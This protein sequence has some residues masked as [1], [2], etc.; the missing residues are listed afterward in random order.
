MDAHLPEHLRDVEREDE[1][2]ASE[3][4]Q[5][6]RQ[7]V[8]DCW[9]DPQNVVDRDARGRLRRPVEHDPQL[10]CRTRGP[11]HAVV[12]QVERRSQVLV[13]RFFDH[14]HVSELL[15]LSD[16]LRVLLLQFGLLVQFPLQSQK[17]PQRHLTRVS[18][19]ALAF[20]ERVSYHVAPFL[21]SFVCALE[22]LQT[23]LVVRRRG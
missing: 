3:S 22:V 2:E 10:G 1:L 17:T 13:W 18:Q 23:Q 19:L 9:A 4:E 20:V 12:R 15:V 16:E 21:S 14:S 8:L 7:V 6:R 5:D 11:Q